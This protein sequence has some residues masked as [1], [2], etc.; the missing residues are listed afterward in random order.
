MALFVFMFAILNR[1][2]TYVVFAGWLVANLRV[3]ALSAGW[4]LTW[5]ERIIPS[6]WTY[7][8]RKAAMS[9]YIAMTVALFIRLFS[10]ELR[11]LKHYRVQWILIAAALQALVSSDTAIPQ[12]RSHNV[13]DGSS[14]SVNPCISSDSR[15]R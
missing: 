11:Q 13:A 5:V 15:D 7:E 12:L 8:F 2:W 1:E 6:D 10:D 3:A 14:S 4:D 9:G